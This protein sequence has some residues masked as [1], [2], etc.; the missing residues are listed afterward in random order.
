MVSQE[1]VLKNDEKFE[2]EDYSS[3]EE[4]QN[5]NTKN[6]EKF[7]KY[8]KYLLNLIDHYENYHDLE[9]TS[10]Q[11][12]NYIANGQFLENSGSISPYCL[13]EIKNRLKN[14]LNQIYIKNGM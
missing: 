9:I 1:S 3:G 14:L 5:I 6:I 12:D 2:A 11:M 8:I 13:S 10:I 7:S 4:L